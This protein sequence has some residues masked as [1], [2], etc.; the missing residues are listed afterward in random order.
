[1]HFQARNFTWQKKQR[2]IYTD[3]T[4]K[5]LQ[6]LS[7]YKKQRHYFLYNTI[8]NINRKQTAIK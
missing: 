1:M 6:T 3:D 7:N 2:E 5:N 4:S 8:L